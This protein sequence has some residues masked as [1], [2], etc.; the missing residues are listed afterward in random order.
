MIKSKLGKRGKAITQ[1]AEGSGLDSWIHSEMVLSGFLTC[2]PSAEDSL[3]VVLGLPE[4]FSHTL[5]TVL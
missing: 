5:L 3:S 4:V 1:G 2:H